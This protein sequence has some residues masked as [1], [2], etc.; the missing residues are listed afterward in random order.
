MNDYH[1]NIE[2]SF[3]LLKETW[4][5]KALRLLVCHPDGAVTPAGRTYAQYLC[6]LLDGQLDVGQPDA[7]LDMGQQ[8]VLA[9]RRHDYDLVIFEE[10]EKPVLKRLLCGPGGLQAT[11]QCHSPI[12]IARH[13]RLPLETI[14]LVT[15]GQTIDNPAIDW[16]V[17]LARPSGAAVTV[18]AVQPALSGLAS[19]ALAG[20]GLADWL[21][22]ETPLGYQLRQI[23]GELVDWEIEGRLRFRDG[24]P[25]EQIRHEVG[26]S[27][28]DL[29]V[30]A[31]DSPNWL[32]RRVPGPLI[33]PLLGWAD[34]P[35]LVARSGKG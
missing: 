6:N 10:S 35:V 3:P 23:A 29:I 11:H 33:G 1:A 31:D 12:L 32:M 28:P 30:I 15:R 24:S 18:L 17:R 9:P 26:E 14:L 27:E 13:P 7:I 4:A 5:N 16:G 22:T 8:P 20:A 34:R 25:A 19:R 21:T 2:L